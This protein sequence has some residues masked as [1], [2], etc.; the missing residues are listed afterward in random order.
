MKYFRIIFDKS[1]V[2]T[3]PVDNILRKAKRGL[4]ALKTM[5]AKGFEQRL[6]VILFNYLVHS[7]LDLGMGILTVSNF[8]CRE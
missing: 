5:V 8:Q 4:T 6:L 1:L 7:V 2:F 3:Y